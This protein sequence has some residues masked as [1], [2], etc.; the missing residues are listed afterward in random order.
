M[1]LK[2]ITWISSSYSKITYYVF[3]MVNLYAYEYSILF[4][5]FKI[6][7]GILFRFAELVIEKPGIKVW[8]FIQL[9]PAIDSY[10]T[11][12]AYKSLVHH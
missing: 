11:F 4:L 2:Y 5:A 6:Y 12:F 3:F 9:D 10:F 8:C 7:G 1:V